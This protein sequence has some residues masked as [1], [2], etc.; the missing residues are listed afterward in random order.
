MASYQHGS[1]VRREVQFQV[2]DSQH[3]FRLQLIED[4]VI[5]VKTLVE[6]GK[7]V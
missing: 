4:R 7:E 5:E 6:L 2:I 3:P 1:K